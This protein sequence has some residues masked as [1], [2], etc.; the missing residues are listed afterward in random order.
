[1]G[2]WIHGVIGGPLPVALV[3]AIGQ[4]AL[5]I[6]FMAFVL[7]AIV[8]EFIKVHELYGSGDSTTPDQLTNCPS[9]GARI[10][11]QADACEYCDSPVDR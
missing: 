11:A 3:E 4:I 1:M 7:L 6:G 5:V 9:C 10:S 2:Y 8:F